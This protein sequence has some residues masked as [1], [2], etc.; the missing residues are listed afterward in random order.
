MPSRPAEEAGDLGLILSRHLEWQGLSLSPKTDQ[1]C[2]VSPGAE[3]VSDLGPERAA[4]P[5]ACLP[6]PTLGLWLL[7]WQMVTRPQPHAP[8]RSLGN[9][10]ELASARDGS[11]S[12]SRRFKGA[13][14]LLCSLNTVVDPILCVGTVQWT[15]DMQGTV[16]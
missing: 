12:C 15:Q 11:G 4:Q 2:T 16:L 8:G 7:C 1:G 13:E 9:D 3:Q 5:T 6:L 14:A 10:A